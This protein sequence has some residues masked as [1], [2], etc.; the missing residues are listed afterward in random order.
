MMRSSN[1]DSST[2]TILNEKIICILLYAKCSV[3]AGQNDS[4]FSHLWLTGLMEV[5]LLPAKVLRQTM[6]DIIICFQEILV[7]YI[8]TY[9]VLLEQ[10]LD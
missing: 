2:T 8:F 9:V 3:F 7:Q 10:F 6:V 4:M 5:F 1:L